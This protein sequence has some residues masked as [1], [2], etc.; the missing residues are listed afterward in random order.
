[1]AVRT[2]SIAA[3]PKPSRG[4]S[5]AERTNTARLPVA[6]GLGG[7]TWPIGITYTAGIT[8]LSIPVGPVKLPIYMSSDKPFLHFVI[9]RGLLK[10][11]DD[12][13][14]KH[15]FTSRAAAITWLLKAALDAKIV[16]KGE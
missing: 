13:R 8:F 12:F 2:A 10:R 11:I 7:K 1:M 9:E 15:R 5:R 4:A 16:P 3:A 6:R 14:F